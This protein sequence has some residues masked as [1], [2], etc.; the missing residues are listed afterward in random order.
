MRKILLILALF[1][2]TVVVAL[3]A[4][5]LGQEWQVRVKP[6]GTLK[7]VDLGHPWAAAKCLYHDP[8]IHIDH[9]NNYQP[10]LA[11][12]WRWI[13]NRTIEFK[14]REG[15]RFHNGERLNAEAVRVNW[16]AYG[17]MDNPFSARFWVIPDETIFRIIDDYTV[18]FTLPQP[19]CLALFKFQLFCL[20]APAFF[21][22]HTFD[23]YNW[24][25]FAEPG[26]WGAGPFQLVEGSVKPWITSDDQIVLKAYEGYWD[27]R[28]PKVQ[29]VVFENKL[30]GDRKEAMRVCRETEGQVD[31]V[32]HI[33]PL[34]TL[35]VAESPFAKVV[36][37]KN[38][39]WF[40]GI[41]NLRNEESKWRDIRLRKALNYAVNRE[42]L[43]KYG[44]KGN[45]YNFGG[46]IPDGAFGHNP[47]LKPYTYDTTKAR[48]L[49]AEAGYPDGFDLKIIALERR[50]L[51]TQIISKML[52]RVGLKVTF[53]ILPEPEF[54]SRVV[55]SI[56]D[57][58]PEEQEWDIHLYNVVD[59]GGNSV[60]LLPWNFIE[61]TGMRWIEYDPSYERMWEE[62][63]T[64]V[65]PE[66]L[67]EKIRQM[68]Q[69]LHD[70]VYAL[71]IYTAM[72]LYAVNKE[73]N[74]VPYNVAALVLRDTSVTE[75][76]WSIR[77]QGE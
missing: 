16:K 57:K 65:D 50:K 54:W 31:I 5:S 73:V 17:D 47:N 75:N 32:S 71:N 27:R 70:Q 15:V 30:I 37:K 52:E 38:V 74:L 3:S 23:E 25:F 72:T 29:R 64:I 42:E 10:H 63:K 19:D 45:A 59:N 51:E 21:A 39:T 44:A 33:R 69:Y 12:D 7:V 46:I 53:E 28:Y 77:G 24:G 13:D 18:R 11:E 41:F 43:W 40:R 14:L 4:P 61:E 20:Y 1:Q 6:R 76:H 60:Y 35:K 36:K 22:T 26:P 2:F 34:D 58:P 48:A 67:E 55:I 8:L 68:V 9:N 56:L 49:L 62:L 66:D